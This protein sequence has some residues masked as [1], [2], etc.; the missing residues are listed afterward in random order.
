[1]SRF[2]QFRT[3]GGKPATLGM[4]LARLARQLGVEAMH[5]LV[6]EDD[7]R[8][9]DLVAQGLRESGYSVNVAYDG[10]EGYLDA[11]LNDYDLV[12]LDLMLPSLDG[13]SIAHKLRAA[14]KATPILMLTARATEQD[15][16]LGLDTGADD[17][18][19]KPFSFGELLA[20]V[21]ALLRRETM[22]RAS[23]MQVGDLEL[24]TAARR[25]WR[26]GREIP[27]SAREY[28][29]LE[30]LVHHSGQ[31]LTRQ[32]LAEHVWSDAEVES[33]VIDVYVRY[34]RQ[35]IDA[36]F[37]TPLIETVRGVGYT[38]RRESCSCSVPPACA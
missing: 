3:L 9:A 31:I 1:V 35:K 6:I 18:L 14:H 2:R 24:D 29:L 10:E 12:V 8:I 26:G 33:N 7:R 15:K 21:R 13:L 34:L 27:L 11:L 28:A 4:D 22:T 38:L 32:Q 30:Y 19:T 5:L 17:Y 23:V 16:I 37:D 25:V 20:R 36:P